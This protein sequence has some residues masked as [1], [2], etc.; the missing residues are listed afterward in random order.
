[1]S[2]HSSGMT[3]INPFESVRYDENELLLAA[4][5]LFVGETVVDIRSIPNP[6]LFIVNARAHVSNRE[7]YTLKIVQ[8]NW[9]IYTT[10]TKKAST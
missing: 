8:N 4:D 3:T 9:I 1:M 5:E 7:E 10:T 2:T 6:V